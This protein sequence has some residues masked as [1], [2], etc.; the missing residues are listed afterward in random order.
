VLL[1][2]EA[3]A[4]GDLPRALGE[5]T[6]AA[7]RVMGVR[8]ASVWRVD[9]T[10]TRIDCL[11]LFDA[12]ERTHVD[13]AK[14][15]AADAPQYF[16]AALTVRCIVA[17]D[18][19]TDPRTCEFTKGYLEPHGITSMLDAPILV[20]GELV[21][22]ICHEHVGPARAWRPWEELAAGTLAD[23][24]GMA[25][26]AAEHAAQSRELE[27][28]R[29][30][31]EKLVEERTRELSESRDNVRALFA[32]SPVALVLTKLSDQSVLM[33]NER[34]AALFEVDA[35]AARGTP[36]TDFWVDPQDRMTMVERLR[37]TGVLEDL[38]AELKASSGRRFW[39]NVS[40]T[41]LVFEGERALLVGVHDVTAK[42][43]AEETLRQNEEV[44]RTML[45]AA[46]IPLVVTGLDDA[47][48][49]FSNKRAADMFGTTVG[50]LVGKRAPDFYENPDDR[51]TFISSLLGSGRVDDFA[52]RLRARD[53]RTFWA[54]LSARTMVLRSTRVF[55][56]GF[57]DLTAQKEIEHKLRDLASMD[58]LTGAFNRRHF[59][60]AASAAIVLSERRGRGSCIAI[61]DVDHFKKVNDVHGH[62]AGD[63]ALKM[64]TRVCQRECRSSDLLARY[65]GEE[66]VVLL[67][68][69]TLEAARAVVERIRRA[70]ATEVVDAATGAFAITVSGGLA[71]RREGE[72]LEALLARADEA[73]YQA[74]RGGRDRI[75][76]A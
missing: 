43:L 29:G 17:D 31:L 65:G 34:A 64:L 73:L 45:E 68:D 7:A 63:E 9:E 48:L 5:I 35:D 56:V 39:G 72:S 2:S 30:N 38:E 70:L 50:E 37:A 19:R 41:A 24:V 66:F 42:K 12:I 75:I 22:V 32:T 69:A 61:L 76:A 26:T 58:G 13:G 44:L 59:Y 15:H 33:A 54:L 71:E 57:S 49:R 60:E 1:R 47:M 53:G 16:E 23:V 10:R 4:R 8:R 27:G 14:I 25:M 18:A 28:L 40:A 21:G 3:I 6:E 46:P 55:M 51:Q 67:P 11:D 62:A 74:K 36:A 52:A 20:R